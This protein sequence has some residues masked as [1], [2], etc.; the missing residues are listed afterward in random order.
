MSRV[1]GRTLR[2]RYHLLRGR[3]RCSTRHGA[4]AVVLWMRHVEIKKQEQVNCLVLADFLIG[5]LIMISY[6]LRLAAV[7]GEAAVKR[8]GMIAAAFLQRSNSLLMR[9]RKI[10]RVV[11]I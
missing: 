11:R 1:V 10:L 9:L 3:G 5:H 2:I 4:A 8:M 7:K 6:V